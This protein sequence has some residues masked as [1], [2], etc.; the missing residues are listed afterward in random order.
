MLLLTNYSKPIPH[1]DFAFEQLVED[2]E[3]YDKDDD[4][5]YINNAKVL[6]RQ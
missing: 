5:D 4:F 1:Q 3:D 2:E 6:C